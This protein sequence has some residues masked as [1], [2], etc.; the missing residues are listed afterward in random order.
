MAITGEL[1]GQTSTI[2]GVE[3]ADADQYL[4][5][6]M[7]TEEYG[8]DILTVQ[9]IKGWDSATP[10]PKAPPHIKGMINLRGTIVPIIDL[11]QC[12]GLDSIQYTS[13]SV[14]IVLLVKSGGKERVMGIVV[15]AVSDVYTISDKDLKPAPDLGEAVN[16]S[17][18][19]GLVN[20]NEKLVILLKIEQLLLVGDLS[21][22]QYLSAEELETGL[23]ADQD[24][25]L[26]VENTP[27]VP[28]SDQGDVEVRA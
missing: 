24:A 27:P 28:D 23:K 16:T 5:F 17:Y 7:N 12:F 13:E 11:R 4:T 2:I 1:K 14:V 22:I 8:V 19:K 18:I 20:V 3:D 10:L 25:K 21:E 26:D 9:E 6:F 15:D